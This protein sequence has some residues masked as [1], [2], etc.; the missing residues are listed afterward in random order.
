VHEFDSFIQH[1]KDGSLPNV[2]FVDGL[3]NLEDDHP[4]ADIQIGEA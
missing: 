1:L 4:P 3:D 2:S